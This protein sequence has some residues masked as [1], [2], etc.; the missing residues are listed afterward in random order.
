MRPIP[1]AEE[2]VLHAR[3]E[4]VKRLDGYELEQPELFQ[5]VVQIIQ[6]KFLPII[7]RHA[8]S[9]QAYVNTEDRIFHN[10]LALLMLIDIFSERGFHAV[11]DKHIR[12]IP[13]QIDS[14]SGKIEFREKVVFRV[15]IN[16]RGSQIRRG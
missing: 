6:S 2:I 12:E 15:I 8:I 4:L 9:G 16:F 7:Q 11:V 13:D 3:Q 1:L 14:A 10:P 5:K